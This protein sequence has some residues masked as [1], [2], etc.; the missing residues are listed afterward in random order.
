MKLVWRHWTG[1]GDRWGMLLVFVMMVSIDYR[2]RFE[3]GRYEVSHFL[4]CTR[5]WFKDKVVAFETSSM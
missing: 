1:G 5:E 2:P 3:E 4:L